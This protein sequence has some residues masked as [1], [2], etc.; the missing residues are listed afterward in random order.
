[1]RAF[2]RRGAE[3]RGESIARQTLESPVVRMPD[4][5]YCPAAHGE[6]RA[7]G[8]TRERLRPFRLS[9]KPLK[10]PVAQ[11]VEQLTFNQ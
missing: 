1:M 5:A 10:E 7:S 2:R 6:A 11:P 8:E 3:T 4:G 9:V